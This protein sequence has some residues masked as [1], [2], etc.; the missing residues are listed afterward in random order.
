MQ[1]ISMNL[2][3]NQCFP[4]LYFKFQTHESARI[5]IPAQYMTVLLIDRTQN[6]CELQLRHCKRGRENRKGKGGEQTPYALSLPLPPR[7]AAGW[8]TTCVFLT[9]NG[10]RRYL[11]ASILLPLRCLTG[12]RISLISTRDVN[13]TRY[14]TM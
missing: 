14:D 5:Q 12:R 4:V 10:A 9:V 3:Y 1:H 13:L 7:T 2:G 6:I 11:A 8:P